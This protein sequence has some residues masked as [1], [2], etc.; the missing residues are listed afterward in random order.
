MRDIELLRCHLRWRWG[1]LLFLRD[2]V[3][4]SYWLCHRDTVR[5]NYYHCHERV[6]HA[7]HPFRSIHNSNRPGSDGYSGMFPDGLDRK[8]SSA[9]GHATRHKLL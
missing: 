8:G 9:H 3:L 6:G 4:A 7:D 2:V 5:F 1:L